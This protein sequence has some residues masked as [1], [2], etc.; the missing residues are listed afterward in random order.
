MTTERGK[1][2]PINVI[3]QP[4]VTFGDMNEKSTYNVIG[5]M[6]GTS[7]DGL[8]LLCCELI[9]QNN[10]WNYRILQ[11]K[12]VRYEAMWKKRLNRVSELSAMELL[13]LDIDFG[14]YIGEHIN[15]FIKKHH[16][17]IDLIAS[18][19]HT[20]FHQPE[21]R[22]TQ[23]IGNGTAIKHITGLP[24]VYDFRTQD[25]LLGGQGAPLVPIGD[26]ELFG[27]YD[28]CLNLGGIAN[29]S[30][31]ENGKRLAFDVCPA[32]M[33]LNWLAMKLGKEYDKDG[34]LAIKGKPVPEL[35]S[36]FNAL[37]YYAQQAPKSLGR[38]DIE[39]WFLPLF[40]EMHSVADLMSTTIEH[41]VYQVSRVVAKSGKEVSILVTG[42]GAHHPLI[43]NQLKE[44]IDAKIH[45]PGRDLID[46]K[47]ALVFSLL[48][49]LRIRNELNV[50]ASVT[51]AKSDSTS[52][53]YIP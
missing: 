22:I 3:Y 36:R 35:L 15:V 14:T 48:G 5:V 50:L 25:V 11:A 40:S 20:I 21:Q 42:G 28:Y 18:H 24:V 37:P 51:G 38:E 39:R 34:L 41:L 53:I 13:R 10:K 32:N 33:A 52:G 6:S 46:F 16:L 47:E 19:G 44:K 29:I 2:N 31:E 23:Q 27:E 12:T 49:V 26:R 7:L 1:F 4:S 9:H 30:Y 17:N 8:D 45:V 43:I